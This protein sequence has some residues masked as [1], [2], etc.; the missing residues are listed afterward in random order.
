MYREHKLR[1][2][3]KIMQELKEDFNST[4]N[5]T[6]KLHILTLSPYSQEQTKEF[7]GASLRMVKRSREL[8][9]LHGILPQVPEMSKGRAISK[10]Q[11]KQVV[12][13]YEQDEISRLCPGRKDCLSV[14]I[15]EEKVKMQKRLILGNLRELYEIYKRDQTMPNI[16]F[17]TFASLRPKWC[18]LSGSSGTHSVCVC[19]HHQNPK[20]QIAAMGIKD[21]TYKV[22]MGHAVCDVVKKECMMH[23]CN[24][25][26]GVNGVKEFLETLDIFDDL[27]NITYQKWVSTDRTKMETITTSTD[28]YIDSLADSIYK[29]TRHSYISR[30]QGQ[31]FKDLKHNLSET[32][33]IVV[34]DFSENY[35]FVVQDEVQGFHWE[36]SQATVH[37]FV[38]YYKQNDVTEHRSFC[39]ISDEL[40]HKTETVHAFLDVLLG[41][42]KDN[43]PAL[44]KI[45]YFSDGCAGQ[46]KN[47]Y[48]FLNLCYHKTDYSFDC[49]WNFFATSHGKN[50]CDGIGGTVKRAVAQASMQRLYANQ[51]LTPLAMFDFVTKSSFESKIKFFYV[52][53]EMVALKKE[54]LAEH[55]MKAVPVKGTQQYHRFVPVEPFG[56]LQV[57]KVS[58]EQMGRSV[59]CLKSDDKLE[60]DFVVEEGELVVGAYVGCVYEKQLWFAMIQEL[61]DE[62]GD[63]L[64]SFL[65][66]Q[67]KSGSHAFPSKVDRLWLPGG[68][69]LLVMSNP[70][71]QAGRRIRYC[72]REDE[73][74]TAEHRCLSAC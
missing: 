67:G 45:H 6:R 56:T 42:L 2:Y 49:E 20:L 12:S 74:T 61:S 32:D 38:L 37:P 52:S 46:Y 5:H 23:E 31:H 16:G 73:M 62:F 25:C 58:T 55:F 22:L 71:L 60:D 21:L 15:D 47:K 48:N 17:S 30:T 57:F 9:K 70:K 41:H 14:R 3:E 8:K 10:E 4:N 44:R 18:V 51:I 1:C 7:F 29:L 36:N 68:D 35:S 66:P 33:C 63:L 24:D 43:Y 11:K 64:V 65:G 13:F 54:S 27:D 40:H 69:I 59:S 26:P 34:G 39:F 19:Q 50:A 53:S 28:D 72:F